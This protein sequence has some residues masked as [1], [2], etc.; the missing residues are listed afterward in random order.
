[1]KQKGDT[2]ILNVSLKVQL[3]SVLAAVSIIPMILVGIVTYSSTIEN[4]Y[5]DK[6]NALKAYS[7][8]IINSLE[9]KTDSTEN[10]LK[11]L[12]VQSDISVVLESFN[13]NPD[14]VDTSRYYS[15]QLS[16]RNMI[17]SSENLYETVFITDKNGKIIMDGS[18]YSQYYKNKTFFNERE[19]EELKKNSKKHYI[20]NPLKS[21]ATGKLLLPISR[22]I[23]SLSGFM[24]V[25]TVMIDLN[26]FTS[27]FN[28]IKPGKSGEIIVMNNNGTII[29]HS[30]SRLLNSKNK[31]DIF[32][33]ILNDKDKMLGFNTYSDDSSEKALFFKKSP[34]AE[35]VVYT[36]IDNNEFLEPVRKFRYFIITVIFALVVAVLVIA[37]IYSRYISKPI[38]SLIE[39]MNQVEKGNLCVSLDFKTRVYE[40]MK[41]KNGFEEMINNLKNLISNVKAASSQMGAVTQY[42]TIASNNS[43][44]HTQQ[45]TCAVRDIAMVI[46]KQAED[47][48][49]ATKS[50]EELA[51]KIN[52]ARTLSNEISTFSEKVN[53]S[54]EAGI[55]LV[56]VLKEKSLMNIKNTSMV[57]EVIKMLGEEM[58]QVNKIIE[59]INNIAKQTNLLSLN[60]AI[61]A[62]RAGESGRGFS[63]VAEEIKKLSEQ[64]TSEAG[65]IN[66]L[67]NNIHSNA[68]KLATAMEGA[69]SA[70]NEQDEAVMHTR[71]AFDQ[72]SESI[73]D[74]SL[75]I[76]NIDSYLEEMDYEK[77]SIVKL[78]R[79]INNVAEEVAICSENMKEH[80]KSQVDIVREVDDYSSSVKILAENLDKSVDMFKL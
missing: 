65:E 13:Y 29:Y 51:V 80:T 35:W 34:P 55:E 28:Q 63:I 6:T 36:Q 43:F 48:E 17:S 37:T 22:P 38:N 71:Q 59:T 66:K 10:L 11:G 26:K 58:H 14:L 61:E 76:K 60:A 49:I 54:A 78:V 64:T 67:I 68:Q 23:R 53:N 50:I 45:T 12:S 31:V 70:T 3:I 40:I 75:K 5:T 44:E 2:S 1:M 79:S 30:D 24:G 47:S 52:T 56:K 7:E 69:S 16:L 42:M 18:K 20:G 25:M 73:K 32:S 74:I 46:D 15:I 77:E 9:A 8:G 27:S 4:I 19:F 39:L 72:I 21:Q 41:L 62:A 33:D 57:G